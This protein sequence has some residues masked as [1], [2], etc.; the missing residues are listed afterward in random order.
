MITGAG[1]GIGKGLAAAFA[2]QEAGLVLV[3]RDG[4]QLR[5]TVGE[6]G[7][8]SNIRLYVCDLSSDQEVMQLQSDVRADFSELNVLVN[9][10][11]AEYPTPIDSKETETMDRWRQLLD[12]NVTTMMR[13]TRALLP[14]MTRNAS[15]INQASIWGLV[16]I[17][18]FSAYVASKHAVIGL[19]RSL[20]WELAPRGIRV[21]AVCPGWIK[22]EASMRSLGY[23]ARTTGRSEDAVL[24]DILAA[25]AMPVLLEPADIAGVYLFLAS[26]DSAAL[27]GQA[28]VAS[29]GD[30]MH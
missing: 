9:N 1:S 13:T 8:K 15:V 26:R 14:L 11:G 18:G 25:Q 28:L 29:R 17:A 4:P 5:Q 20:A 19:T 30:V 22:T 16:G 6:L 23:M 7:A 12:N 3:D 2:A 21:N 27:T 24:K 10:A